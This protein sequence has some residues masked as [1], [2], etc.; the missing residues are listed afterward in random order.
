MAQLS[1]IVLLIFLHFQHW[2]MNMSEY[3]N[4]HL[5][6]DTSDVHFTQSVCGDGHYGLL[7]G[8]FKAV[9]SEPTTQR[10]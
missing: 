4:N 10:P 7:S 3:K 2:E 9:S 8:A 5:T 1:I 6:T